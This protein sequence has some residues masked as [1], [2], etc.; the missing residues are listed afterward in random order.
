MSTEKESSSIFSRINSSANIA[1]SVL[2]AI[3]IIAAGVWF[4]MQREA[5]PKANIEHTVT[6][7]QINNDWT[8]VRVSITISNPGKRL[9]D[10]ESGIIRI[11]KILPLDSKI[12]SIF[13]RNESPISKKD[14]KVRWPRIGKSYEPQLDIKIEP[15]EEDNLDYEFIIPSYVKTVKI[16]SYFS[17]QENPPLGWAKSTIYDLKEI[18]G[19]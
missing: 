19:K 15:G 1:Q 2:T 17:K 10:F 13:E 4:L 5:A 8:W 9:L 7:R 11:Q 16:Y 6:H 12:R 3:A 14:Y 18:G